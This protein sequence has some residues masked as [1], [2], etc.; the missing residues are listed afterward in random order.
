MVGLSVHGGCLSV[1]W[2][3]GFARSRGVREEDAGV[4]GSEL[5]GVPGAIVT[6]SLPPSLSIAAQADDDEFRVLKGPAENSPNVRNARWFAHNS[7]KESRRE[8]KSA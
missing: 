8:A 7:C 6:T 4:W 3:E 5:G 1:F 2:L